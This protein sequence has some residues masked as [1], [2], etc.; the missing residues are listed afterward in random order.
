MII[1]LNEDIIIQINKNLCVNDIL[2]LRKSFKN[3]YKI[4]KEFNYIRLINPETNF[5]IKKDDIYNIELTIYDF[6]IVYDKY[7]LLSNK[8]IIG[9]NIIRTGICK[10]DR[11]DENF[12]LKDLI[13]DLLCGDNIKCLGIDIG[14]FYTLSNYFRKKKKDITILNIKIICLKQMYNL[15]NPYWDLTLYCFKLVISTFKKIENVIHVNLKFNTLFY[16]TYRLSSTINSIKCIE[17][18]NNVDKTLKYYLKKNKIN[19][20][21]NIKLNNKNYNLFFEKDDSFT[22]DFK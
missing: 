17:N 21:L 18:Y 4:L 11:L 20:D 16:N 1:D 10:F 15:V 7:H 5:Y 14:Y 3:N 8:N 19:I 22:L 6:T 12:E 2:L 9:L 13:Y